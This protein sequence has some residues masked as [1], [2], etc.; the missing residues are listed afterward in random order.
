MLKAVILCALPVFCL[1][2]DYAYRLSL[3]NGGDL[4]R[5]TRAGMLIDRVI[6]G[7]FAGA[8]L[9]SLIIRLTGVGSEFLRWFIPAVGATLGFSA[10]GLIKEKSIARFFG[11]NL[12][13]LP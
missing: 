3:S 8:M 5:Q 4:R 12:P 9:G 6:I 1:A 10:L 13:D 7:I 2:L 11:V